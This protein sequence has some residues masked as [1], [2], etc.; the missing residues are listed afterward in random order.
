MTEDDLEALTDWLR[1]RMPGYDLELERGTEDDT[2][3][4]EV[5]ESGED[6]KSG[7]RE[8]RGEEASAGLL[9]MPARISEGGDWPSLAEVKRALETAAVSSLLTKGRHLALRMPDRK[10]DMRKLWVED[11]AEEG[12]GA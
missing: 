6:G 10:D 12:D 11:V 2:L 3:V 8:G 4:L 7:Q 9:W 5:R 1:G